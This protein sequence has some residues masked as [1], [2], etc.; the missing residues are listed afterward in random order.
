M[1]KL[2]NG[3]LVAAAVGFVLGSTGPAGASVLITVDQIGPDVVETAS[4]TIDLTDLTFDQ[5]LV[6]SGG[7][8]PSFGA[9]IVGP[10][11]ASDV[12]DGYNGIIGPASFGPG[13][14]TFATLGSGDFF[15]VSSFRNDV[16]VPVGYV[17]GSP[18]SGTDTYTG[19]TI[20]SL[21]AIPGTYTWTWGAGPDADSLTLQINAPGAATPEPSS[22][23]LFGM[24]V[25]GLGVAR[26][27]KRK[28]VA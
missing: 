21:G 8:N 15:G 7:M 22:F 10:V 11:S 17:S 13:A 1:R 27:R 9:T 14:L 28:Q 18:L 24:A 20:S 12:Y 23:I 4:G 19:Q 5:P 26:C 25:S 16:D 6:R 2:V 3:A